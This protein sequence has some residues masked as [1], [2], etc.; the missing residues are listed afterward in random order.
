MG[1]GRK[2]DVGVGHVCGHVTLST[3]PSISSSSLKIRKKRPS[4][5]SVPSQHLDD[6]FPCTLEKDFV[7]F[8]RGSNARGK[9]VYGCFVH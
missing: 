2:W 8:Q 7:H 9:L 6:A 1:W 5:G 4:H 3:H